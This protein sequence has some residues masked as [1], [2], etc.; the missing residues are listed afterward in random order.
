[1]HRLP[2]AVL[3]LACAACA[4]GASLWQAESLADGTLYSDQVARRAGDLITILVKET[5]AVSENQKTETTRENEL[6]AAV[7][8][9]P[10]NTALPAVVGQTSVGRL[11]AVAMN[12]SKEFEGEGKYEAD[13][14]VRATVTGR[15]VDVLDNGNLL[16]EGRR[17]VKVNLDTKTIIITGI[18]RTADIRS[19]NTVWSEKLHDFQLAIEGDGPLTRAQQEGWLG[20]IIDVVWPF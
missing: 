14:E 15:V 20:R 13:S 12:S 2:T 16:V 9:L 10:Q 1:M 18:V 4:H 17:Q 3:L 6:E 5:T 7:T 8:M 19:D 11:P